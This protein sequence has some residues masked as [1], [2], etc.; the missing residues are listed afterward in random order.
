[1]HRII[2]LAAKRMQHNLSKCLTSHFI[3]GSKD[4]QELSQAL[5]RLF[6]SNEQKIQLRSAEYLFDIF[7]AESILLAELASSYLV[8]DETAESS[9]YQEMVA[10]G[11]WQD[12]KKMLW[13]IGKKNTAEREEL[14]KVLQRLTAYCVM[15]NSK[16]LPHS[17]HQ[18]IAYSC[19]MPRLMHVATLC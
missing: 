5:L 9:E 15:K 6:D 14:I 19:G 1:M 17:V 18:N 8:G 11:T 12:E 13:N 7:S 3:S 4:S 2:Q 10:L 16:F